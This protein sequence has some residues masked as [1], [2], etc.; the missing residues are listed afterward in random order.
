MLRNLMLV[1]VS[2]FAVLQTVNGQGITGQ[3]SGTVVDQTGAVVPGALVQLKYDLTDQLRTFT[4]EANG[5]FMF[6]NLVPGEY[7]VHIAQAGFKGYEQK[8][9]ML[10]AQER[11]DLHEIKLSVGDVGAS[12]EVEAEGARVA[13]DSSA[14]S[15]LINRAIIEAT[16]IRG[17]DYLGVLRGLPGVAAVT[18]NEQPGYKSAGPAINGG[19]GQFVITLDGIV[20]QDAGGLGTTGEMAPSLDAIGEVQVLTSNYNAEYGVRA[21]GQF[22]VSIKNGTNQFHGS[23]YYFWRHEQFNA[24]EWFNNK[25]NLPKPLYRYQNPGG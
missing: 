24:N 10:S 12:V 21:G 17:R 3:I 5:S 7:S 23:A 20:A 6:T 19:S 4:T 14:R 9:I 13:T 22:N 2:L 15:V 1:L 11:I 8:S 18:T 25:T 16:P